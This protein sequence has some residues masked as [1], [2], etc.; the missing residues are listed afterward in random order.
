MRVNNL[1][2]SV[3]MHKKILSFILCELNLKLSIMLS[4]IIKIDNLA[5]DIILY[6]LISHLLIFLILFNLSKHLFKPN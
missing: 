5:H 1:F 4:L 2:N 6:L 3:I